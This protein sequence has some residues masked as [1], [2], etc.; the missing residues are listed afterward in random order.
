MRAS[1]VS[2]IPHFSFCPGLCE[3][4]LCCCATYFSGELNA[5][6]VHN[7]KPNAALKRRPRVY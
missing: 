2:S 3:S 5:L 7:R 4:L 6:V 1:V